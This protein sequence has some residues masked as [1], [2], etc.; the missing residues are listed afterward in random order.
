M[1]HD[2]P[3][4]V[5][6]MVADFCATSGRKIHRVESYWYK[7]ADEGDRDEMFAVR[8]DIA[9]ERDLFAFLVDGDRETSATVGAGGAIVAMERKTFLEFI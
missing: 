8:V 9:D 7:M 6:S 2:F 3:Q 1:I 5:G 4:W